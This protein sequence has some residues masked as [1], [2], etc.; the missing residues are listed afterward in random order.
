M[1][2]SWTKV[3]TAMPINCFYLEFDNL[4]EKFSSIQHYQRLVDKNSKNILTELEDNLAG[5]DELNGDWKEITGHSYNNF[6]YT[7]P[8]SGKSVMYSHKKTSIAQEI[9]LVYIFKNKQYQWLL[10]EAYEEYEDFIENIYAHCGCIDLEFWH[11]EHKKL[12]N[13]SSKPE[14]PDFLKVSKHLGVRKILNRIR[15]IF[16]DLKKFERINPVHGHMGFY[17]ALIEKIRHVVVHRNGVVADKNRFII[18]VLHSCNVS[19][20]GELEPIARQS[21]E[22][23]FGTGVFQNHIL[24][25]EQRVGYETRMPMYINRQEYLAN[26]L[27]SYG[28][29]L[30]LKMTEKFSDRFD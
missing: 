8:L 30:V 7:E 1:H 11:Q 2:S 13:S 15:S 18:E 26:K 9:D 29:L 24:L 23:Y 10:A 25:L 17:L 3:V 6:Y 20:D 21:I 5:S 27:L 19:G 28:H 14:F 22:N 16:V 4:K 12:L